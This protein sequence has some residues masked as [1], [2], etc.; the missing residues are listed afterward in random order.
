MSVYFDIKERP[1]K[2][3]ET[4]LVRDN[5]EEAEEDLVAELYKIFRKN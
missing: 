1:Y 2:I 4:V 5:R 3:T